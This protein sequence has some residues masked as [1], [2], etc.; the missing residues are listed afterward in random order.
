M[1]IELV[2]SFKLIIK[3][4]SV[5]EVI[6]CLEIAQQREL[7]QKIKSK[8]NIYRIEIY[9]NRKMYQTIKR[10]IYLNPLITLDV[11]KVNEVEI[12]RE[13]VYSFKSFDILMIAELIEKKPVF[14]SLE[15]IDI[16]YMFF[17]KQTNKALYDVMTKVKESKLYQSIIYNLHMQYIEIINN[18]EL[19]LYEEII[20]KLSAV[21]HEIH[22]E[23]KQDD[24]V[25]F[26]GIEYNRYKDISKKLKH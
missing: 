1:M 12:V 18:C 9:V 23:L 24:I 8:D 22:R 13:Y 4:I 21:I 19:I 3:S 25:K 17:T 11:Y 16:Y 7:T 5:K 10:F 14:S 15:A 26:K 2:D 6:K 20:Y